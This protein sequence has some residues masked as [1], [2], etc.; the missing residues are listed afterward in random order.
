ML[1][2]FG[3][4]FR[5]GWYLITGFAPC[6]A[7]AVVVATN[8]MCICFGNSVCIIVCA[9]LQV[10][11]YLVK[12]G[13][14]HY[15]CGSNACFYVVSACDD[16]SLLNKQNGLAE[17]TVHVLRLNGVGK[18][19]T[20]YRQRLCLQQCDDGNTYAAMTAAM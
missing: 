2:M 5:A 9:G 18:Q 20:Q 6:C 3:A 12:L 11:A 14:K 1:R 10:V 7:C 4:A 8:G 19:Y 16:R 13:S 15:R 17:R